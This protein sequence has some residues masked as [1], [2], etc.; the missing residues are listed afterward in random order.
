MKKPILFL[1]IFL[2]LIVDVSGQI[3]F[4]PY[5]VFPTGSKADAIV[6]DDLNNDGRDDVVL[7]TEEMPG[8]LNDYNIFI[9]YQGSDGTLNNPILIPFQEN[10]N[11]G[12][13]NLDI[14]DLNGDQKKDIVLATDDSINIYYQVNQ[15]A[16]TLKRYESGENADAVRIGDLNNDG[17]DDIALSYY[18]DENLDVYYQDVTGNLNRVNY[19]AMNCG[20]ARL[21]I[22]DLNNDSLDDLLFFGSE[23]FESGL[24][25]YLQNSS[26]EL[27]PPFSYDTGL[28]LLNNMAIGDLNGD[29]RPD[30]AIT[31]GG[32]YPAD[33]AIHYKNNNTWHFNNPVVLTAYD[34][35]EPV[36]I[37]DL[38]CD[39]KNEIIIAHRGW[40]A[41]TVYEQD[42]SGNYGNYTR[43]ANTMGEDYCMYSMD[44]GDLNS[45]GMQDVA[46]VTYNLIILYNDSKPPVSDTLVYNDTLQIKPIVNDSFVEV[47]TSDTL[48]SYIVAETERFLVRDFYN[49]IAYMEYY[50]E[51]RDGYICGNYSR[52]SVLI[53][54]LYRED[55]VYLLSDS[56]LISIS[57]DTLYM[58]IDDND[59]HNAVTI[60]P[61]PGPGIFTIEIKGIDGTLELTITDLYGVNVSGPKIYT[62]G[63]YEL[64]LSDKPGGVYLVGIR[65]DG[66]LAG[67][68][69]ILKL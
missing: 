14:G 64:D 39:G 19:P 11:P 3:D 32:N 24:Y 26:G 18:M 40:H 25:F 60:C 44:I 58:G 63:R 54:S 2:A 35:P 12:G 37:N 33:L 20:R 50:Y 22:S 21:E 42:Q 55:E 69:K 23:G 27:D 53:D 51:I 15:A 8:G 13:P 68:L 9:Y 41:L 61:N 45:D 57:I 5:Q 10:Y 4:K 47:T 52:D 1:I 34:I 16:F 48:P 59:I 65:K 66:V 49:Y 31:A 36:A 29:N 7:T 6:V 28:E 56:I 43:F 30:L 67:S 17:I 38:N 46:L 62:N